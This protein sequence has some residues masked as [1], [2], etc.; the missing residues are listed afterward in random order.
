MKKNFLFIMMTVFL[1]W[2]WFGG[3]T[4][5]DELI[6]I[7]A[8]TIS[9]VSSKYAY[10]QSEILPEPTIKIKVEWTTT[11]LQ[12]WTDYEI[13]YSDNTNV[14]TAKITITWTGKYTGTKE[15]TFTITN[16]I[17]DMSINPTPEIFVVTWQPIEPE[18]TRVYLWS[19]TLQSWT[20]YEITYSDNTNVWTAKITI[21]W[22]GKYTG[23]KEKTFKIIN[24]SDITYT[25][26]WAPEAANFKATAIS[27]NGVYK[28]YKDAN[29]TARL[30]PW[31]LAS[32]VTLDLNWHTLT[33]TASDYGILLSRAWTESTHKTFSI[34]DSSKDKWWKLIVNPNATAIQWQWKY[35]DIIIWEWVTVDW[36]AVTIL[37]ENMT[38]SVEGTINWWSDFAVATNGSSTKNATITINEWAILTS[39]VTAIY[40]PWNTWLNTTI[41]WKVTWKTAVEIRGWDLTIWETAQLIS[42][43][44]FSEAPNWNWTTINGAALAVSQHTTDLPINV[45]INW[46]KFEWLKT[47]YEKDLHSENA[48]DQIK[49]TINT[50]LFQWESFSENV[51]N[52]IQWWKFSKKPDVSYIADWYYA[53][54]IQEE[55]YLFEITPIQ[56]ISTIELTWIVT[57]ISWDAPSIDWISTTTTWITLTTKQWQDNANNQTVMTQWDKFTKGNQYTLYIGFRVD[58]WYKL[59]NEVSCG[60]SCTVT[61][62]ESSNSLRLTYTAEAKKYTVTWG[63]EWQKTTTEVEEWSTPTYTGTPTKAAD[64]SYTYSFSGWSLD[65][66]NVVDLS[67]Q[68]IT[69]D[70]TYT[71]IFTATK[72]TTSTWWWGGGGGGSSSSYSCKNLPENA[73]ANNT[74][75]PSSRTDYF[76]DTDTS[77]VCSFVCKEGYEW[78]KSASKCEAVTTR[79]TTW[80]NTKI[81]EQ[82]SE[83]NKNDTTANPQETLSDGLT[84][85]LH[86][87]YNFAHKYGITTM[88][89][90]AEANMYSQLNRIAMAK[91]LSQYAINVLGKT[92]DTSKVV[93]TFS[94]VTPELN[95]EYS[96]AVTL[97]YQLG[98]MWINIEEFRPFDPVIRAE[99]ATALSRLLFATPDGEYEWTAQYYVNH[100][101]KL[102]EEKIITNNDPLLNELRGYVMIMLMRSAQ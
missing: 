66:K 7:S 92:P 99:F 56:E 34:I 21:T 94:D 65:W 22:T 42:N 38:L 19:I 32:D 35:N 98:I 83:E 73:V 93:P 36:W 31:I 8:S 25:V 102:V 45:I 88:P 55:P 40:L 91:M 52:F 85:E 57:P 64:N 58:E 54:P 69:S 76:Y 11:T 24:E 70:V 43:W 13:T 60:E 10:T 44:Q 59:A 30:V 5:A 3:V 82:K 47:V 18:I 4:M 9:N 97:A 12:S 17:S 90:A 15:K 37:S 29:L 48:R 67:S 87:A 53:K 23:T 71:A 26:N 74:K 77:K 50:W 80:D 39:D 72:K 89:S 75:K 6:D 33:S 78:N 16:S 79:T 28:L 68:Q 14:W 27:K 101:A 61:A 100:L 63:I 1:A 96:D 86:N 95:Q 81:D 2:A 20:D 49:V 46:W 41:N 84:T 51:T 62:E